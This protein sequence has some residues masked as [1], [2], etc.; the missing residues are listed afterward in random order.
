MI[1]IPVDVTRG[2]HGFRSRSTYFASLFNMNIPVFKKG[3]CYT[4]NHTNKYFKAHSN[5]GFV[6]S[7]AVSSRAMKR[8]GV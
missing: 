7:S 3:M 2:A 6:G 5:V 8:R 1:R 4:E